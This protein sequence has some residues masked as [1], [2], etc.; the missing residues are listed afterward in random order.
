MK[1]VTGENKGEQKNKK[2]KKTKKI[3]TKNI[4]S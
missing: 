4:E 1:G 3:I 2:N